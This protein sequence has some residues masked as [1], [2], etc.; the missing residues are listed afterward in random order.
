MDRRSFQPSS[1]VGG[2]SDQ[3]FI[4]FWILL[5][6]KEKSSETI[7]YPQISWYMIYGTWWL[8]EKICLLQLNEKKENCPFCCVSSILLDSRTWPEGS[9]ELGLVI[10]SF[11]LPSNSSLGIGSLVF[12]E[13]L[14]SVRGLYGDLYD[15]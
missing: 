11:C 2:K 3:I 7:V 9:Y 8:I 5:N 4:L 13:T 1:C 12:S 10:P 15:S 14:H 6:C